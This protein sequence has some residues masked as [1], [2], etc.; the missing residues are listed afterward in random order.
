MV[1]A[2]ALASGR[3]TD[4]LI[5]FCLTPCSGALRPRMIIAARPAV[6][7]KRHDRAA[8]RRRCS[9]GAVY[10]DPFRRAP[11]GTSNHSRRT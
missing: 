6:S 4:W 8:L 5:G 11:G 1:S 3:V 2:A 7:R 9:G 10:A